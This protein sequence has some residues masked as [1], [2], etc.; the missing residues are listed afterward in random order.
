MK[1]K[2]KKK[3]SGKNAGFKYPESTVIFSDCPKPEDFQ[4]TVIKK[5]KQ[6][7]STRG[8]FDIFAS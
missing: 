8:S 4:S 6:H 3:K 1:R 5:R 7:M 2:E